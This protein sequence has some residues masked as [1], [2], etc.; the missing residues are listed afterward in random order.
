MLTFKE[1]TNFFVGYMLA[2]VSYF[3]T[4]TN[5]SSRTKVGGNMRTFVNEWD[6]VP[7]LKSNDDPV[8]NLF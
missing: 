7:P 3:P 1:L 2:Y 4:D 5:I 8:C 6:S